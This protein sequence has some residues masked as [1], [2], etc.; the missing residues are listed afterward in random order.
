MTDSDEWSP[1]KE[2]NEDPGKIARDLF[3]MAKDQLQGS[4]NQPI[5]PPFP[6]VQAI[7]FDKTFHVRDISNGFIA[8]HLRLQGMETQNIDTYCQSVCDVA[9]CFQT[10]IVALDEMRK[11]SLGCPGVVES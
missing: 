1:D 9:A 2:K 8:S 7:A 10:H 11:R 6:H 5:F 4:F 3:K